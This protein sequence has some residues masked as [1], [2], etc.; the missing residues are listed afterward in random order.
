MK[1]G[2]ILKGKNVLLILLGVLFISLSFQQIMNTDIFFGNCDDTPD[3][4][5]FR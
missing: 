5:R 4:S 1:T 3:S 2:E